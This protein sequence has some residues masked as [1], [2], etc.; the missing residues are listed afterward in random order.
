MAEVSSTK[1]KEKKAPAI[2]NTTPSGAKKKA[3]DGVSVNSNDNEVASS[4]EDD[5]V[6]AFK[7]EF[8]G[9]PY[10]ELSVVVRC[11]SRYMPTYQ[12][13]ELPAVAEL[14]MKHRVA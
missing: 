9:M 2:A 11:G 13:I 7:D 4:L 1:V 6:K 8:K 10:T 12:E 3:S 14:L 5:I